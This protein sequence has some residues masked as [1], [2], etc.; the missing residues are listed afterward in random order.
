[1]RRFRT[2]S[3]P[4]HAHPLVRRLFQEMN[5]QRIGMTDMAERVGMSRFTING[6][7]TRHCPRIVELEACYNVLG[8]KLTLLVLKD[9]A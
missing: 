5:H 9:D 6:W 1:M 3:V 4:Q 7:R 8:Y 2:L